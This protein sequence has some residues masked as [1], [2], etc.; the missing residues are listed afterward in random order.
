M[1]NYIELFFD[2]SNPNNQGLAFRVWACDSYHGEFNEI[3]SGPVDSISELNTLL[4]L[5]PL[6]ES[7]L[8]KKQA[9]ELM[10]TKLNSK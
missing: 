7:S 9:L 2:D 6:S 1:V 10:L 5:G 4:K 3:Q 8:T